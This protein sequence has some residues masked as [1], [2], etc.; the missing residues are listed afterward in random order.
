METPRNTARQVERRRALQQERA[1]QGLCVQCSVPHDGEAQKC[2]RCTVRASEA[3]WRWK[4]GK[5]APEPPAVRGW[6]YDT[7]DLITQNLDLPKRMARSIMAKM[8]PSTSVDVDD[9]IGDGMY[10]LV[11]AGRTY[12]PSYETPFRSWAS[13]QVRGE[14]Y[15]GMRRWLKRVKQRP[16]FVPLDDDAD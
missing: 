3:V 10:G 2:R 1:A 7:D 8:P 14:I 5:Q 11:L 6:N 12:D 4:Q 9:L 16:T 13:T 15:G